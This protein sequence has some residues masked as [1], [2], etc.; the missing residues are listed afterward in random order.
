[1]TRRNWLQSLP[2]LAAILL[3]VSDL[4]NPK[5]FH[6]SAFGVLNN[7]CNV[8]FGS[9]RVPKKSRELVQSSHTC[10]GA[11]PRQELSLHVRKHQTDHEED[12]AEG[13]IL[14]QQRNNKNW[15]QGGG[16]QAPV[17][18]QR[19][20]NDDLDQSRRN[21]IR[22]PG[23]MIGMAAILAQLQDLQ[24]ANAEDSNLLQ[25]DQKKIVMEMSPENIPK[26][27]TNKP[28]A[29]SSSSIT[30]TEVST[31]ASSPLGD[32]DA[33]TESEL[34]RIA[35]FEKAAPSVVYIDTFVEQRDAFSTNV[36]EVPVGTGSGFVWDDRGHIVTNCE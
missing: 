10:H 36:M 6:V 23:T 35:V 27:Y 26:K 9:S 5:A 2:I 32:L 11:S 12:G 14:K 21:F 19:R 4:G 33:L 25:I 17:P 18:G 34:R 30:T 31:A 3:L 8:V 16:E 29:S 22:T 24:A 20:S 13:H 7:K 28:S 15:S 1:M